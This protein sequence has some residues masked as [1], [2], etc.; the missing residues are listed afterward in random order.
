LEVFQLSKSEL[1]CWEVSNILKLPS[2]KHEVMPLPSV[3]Q[4]SSSLQHFAQIDRNRITLLQIGVTKLC[5]S[6]SF[7]HCELLCAM[8][9]R[10]PWGRLLHRELSSAQL[11]H[12][13]KRAKLLATHKHVSQHINNVPSAVC[14][15]EGENYIQ[16]VIRHVYVLRVALLAS[17][18][19]LVGH[20]TAPGAEV[21]PMAFVLAWR[22]TVLSSAV[23]KL[24]LLTASA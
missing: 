21:C 12:Q 5:Q 17:A 13:L 4:L 10:M 15:G 14:T 19:A 9:T 6:S 2:T 11:M 24:L 23:P 22:M 3:L 8:L 7:L 16:N 18:G 1:Q 20:W